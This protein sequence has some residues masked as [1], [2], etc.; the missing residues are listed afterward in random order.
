[1]P[2]FDAEATIGAALA[3]VQGQTERRVEILVVDEGSADRTGEIATAAADADARVRYIRLD[4]KLGPGAARNRA[5]ALARGRWIA[6]LDSN[7]RFHA[8][9]LERLIALG[10]RTGADIVSDDLLLCREAGLDEVMIPHE[11]LA[12]ETLLSTAAFIKGN[13]GSRKHPRCSYGFMQPLFRRAFLA[14]NRLSYDERHPFAGDFLFYV[15][16]LARGARWWVT[17]EPMCFRTVREGSPAEW[18]S[19]EALLRLR[20]AAQRLLADRRP[21]I[22][23]SLAHAIRQRRAKADRACYRRAFADAVKRRRFDVAVTLLFESGRSS[24]AS[25][26]RAVGRAPAIVS[27]ALRGG[28]GQT[29]CAPMM[30]ARHPGATRNGFPDPV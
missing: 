25:F 23:P 18:R 14:R 21:A 19:T 22:D 4:A 30:R 20:A 5:F 3:S 15:E 1:V 8:H 24:A 10:E 12:E 27:K 16:C 11:Q 28:P 2:A 17:P 13:I 6:L 29:A 7:D 26:A 9:R